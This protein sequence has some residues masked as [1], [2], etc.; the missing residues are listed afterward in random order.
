[1]IQSADPG[2]DSFDT[3]AETGVGNRAVFTQVEVLLES[4]WREVVFFNA[5][6]LLIIPAYKFGADQE[7]KHKNYCVGGCRGER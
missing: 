4:G 7:G 3:H 6:S 2:Y 1:M 5:P